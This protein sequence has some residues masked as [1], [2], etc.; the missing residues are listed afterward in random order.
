MIHPRYIN[1]TN[2]EIV[3]RNPLDQ[4]LGELADFLWNDPRPHREGKF[5]MG[6]LATEWD[7][8]YENPTKAL[9][10]CGTAACAAGWGLFLRCDSNLF[11][12]VEEAYGRLVQG[13]MFSGG[14][15]YVDNSPD[16]A[17]YRI[18]H[19]LKHRDPAL[20]EENYSLRAFMQRHYP[21]DAFWMESAA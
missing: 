16:G 3:E 17:S 21:E 15:T 9:A 12:V 5:E 13:W 10:R 4:E 2:A 6:L 1:F 18:D 20:Y 14:W 19:W 11:E 7:P 8:T